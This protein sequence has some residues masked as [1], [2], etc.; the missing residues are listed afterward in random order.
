MKSIIRNNFLLYKSYFKY[1][2]AYCIMRLFT[3]ILVIVQPIS[4]I[5][6]FQLFMDAIFVENDIKKSIIIAAVTAAVN[7]CAAAVNWMMNNKLTPISEQKNSMRY[8]CE[9]LNLSLIHI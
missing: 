9:I 4:S 5:Y 8:I 2:P 1:E 7:F 3:G 6:L